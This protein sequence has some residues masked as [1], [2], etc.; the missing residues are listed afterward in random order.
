[1]REG[2]LIILV[3]AGTSVEA[4]IP[5]SRDM[6]TKVEDLLQTNETWKHFYSLY[7]CIKAS[8]ISSDIMKGK[9]Y[10][11]PD[12][13][14]IVNTLSELE[15]NTD[16]T[17]YPFVAGWHQR[18]CELAGTDFVHVRDF[19]RLI[20]AQLRD[21]IAIKS[22]ARASYYEGFYRLRDELKF[23]LRIFSLN[24][25]L[26][27]EQFAGTGR[28]LEMGFDRKTESWDFRRFEARDEEAPHIYLYKLHGSITWYREKQEGNI[29][30]LAATPQAEPDLIFGTDYKMQYIDPYL[31]YTYELRRYSLEARIILTI[32]YSFR[33]AHINGIITQ[34]LQ[35]DK[36]RMLVAVSKSA[37][38]AIKQLVG[39]EKQCRAHDQSAAAFLQNINIKQLEELAGIPH[40]ETPFTETPSQEP[41]A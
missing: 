26:C 1:M 20:V 37:T 3:G 35:H 30:K 36:N 9:P 8:L 22:Y 6:V 14:R 23:A 16:C 2:D 5:A 32:G 25:D 38:G 28:P 7:Q 27:L 29:L 13:E 31:F 17:L 15:K 11:E 24:Y 34:S 39:I 19:R 10:S 18:V 41:T 12:I 4:G 21:W 33:D 40:E